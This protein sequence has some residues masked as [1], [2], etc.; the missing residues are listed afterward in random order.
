[1]A[2]TLIAMAHA[3]I[4]SGD[5]ESAIRVSTEFAS[6]T[7]QNP[8]VVVLRHT[9]FSVED[10]RKL[11]DVAHAAPLGD[12]KVVIV[13]ATRFFH[14]AQNALLKLFEEPPPD[15]TL[16]LVVLSEGMLLST[17]RSRLT[18]L[19]GSTTG[20]LSELALEF[21]KADAGE[22]DKLVAKLIDRSKSDKDAEKQRARSE[23]IRLVEDL[24]RVADKGQKGGKGTDELISFIDDLM[25]F[26]PI[27]HTRSAPLK[28]IFEHLTLVIPKDLK[29][30]AV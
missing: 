24:I 20:G 12:Q 10:A 14:E 11:S 23:A 30:V 4:I 25:H 3:Y 15:T 19:P 29:K 17:L 7:Y 9:L 18:P 2:Y 5:A 16:I 22:R 26:L 21:L 1:M 28:L 8:D 27:L 13:T 6:R